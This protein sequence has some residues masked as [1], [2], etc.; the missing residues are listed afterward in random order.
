LLEV[1]VDWPLIAIQTF[2]RPYPSSPRVLVAIQI[3][4]IHT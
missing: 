2:F 3:H 4:C 1:K